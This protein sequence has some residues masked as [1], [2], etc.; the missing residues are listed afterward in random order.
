MSFTVTVPARDLTPQEEKALWEAVEV[1]KRAGVP[2]EAVLRKF[3]WDD[4]R[5]KELRDLIASSGSLDAAMGDA[6]ARDA[7]KQARA[8]AAGQP[9]P[10]AQPA[11]AASSGT[12]N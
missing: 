4:Q 3:G 7:E 10:A 6:E 11:V 5:I 2:V 12:A 9:Q 1:A 8:E